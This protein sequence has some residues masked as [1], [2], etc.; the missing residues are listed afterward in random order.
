MPTLFCVFIR[1]FT[2]PIIYRAATK[3]IAASCHLGHLPAAHA[4]NVELVSQ[5]G[6][7]SYQEGGWHLYLGSSRRTLHQC[8]PLNV[9]GIHV[10][11][12]FISCLDVQVL[13]A[14]ASTRTSA[15]S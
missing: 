5:C 7:L 1:T 10:L 3:V 8:F 14:S 4:V 2:I 13:I 15:G 12:K 11:G 6:H 9:L